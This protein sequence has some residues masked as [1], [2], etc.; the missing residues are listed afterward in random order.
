MRDGP[1]AGLRL[2][3]AILGRGELHEYHLA[4]AARGELLRRAGQI[5]LAQQ[6]FQHALRLAKQEPERRL[7]RRRLSELALTKDE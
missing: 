4:H 1:T 2:V 5:E 6:A 7:L 3:D